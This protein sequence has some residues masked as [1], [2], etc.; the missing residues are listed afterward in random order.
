MQ[1]QVRTHTLDNRKLLEYPLSELSIAITRLYKDQRS[2]FRQF[3]SKLLAGEYVTPMIYLVKR[4]IITF[5]VDLLFLIL[6]DL[7]EDI[8]R[9]LYLSFKARLEREDTHAFS[10]YLVKNR[11]IDYVR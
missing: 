7:K 9:P 8:R 4:C 5:D 11:H 2:L 3:E 6:E 1:P 10:M